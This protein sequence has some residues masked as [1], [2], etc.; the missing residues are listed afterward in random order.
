L[1]QYAE[2][3]KFWTDATANSSADLLQ[4]SVIS[5]APGL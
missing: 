1:A 5:E 4:N 3:Q 2:W